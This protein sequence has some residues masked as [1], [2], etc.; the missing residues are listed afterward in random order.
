MTSKKIT[1]PVYIEGL[2]K[3]TPES[4]VEFGQ[5][6]SRLFA[7]KHEEL[8]QRMK[9]WRIEKQWK[10]DGVFTLIREGKSASQIERQQKVSRNTV[11][12]YKNKLLLQEPNLICPCGLPLSHKG[13]CSIR[14]EGRVYIITSRKS[15][16][17]L[18]YLRW[19]FLTS[20]I[21]VPSYLHTIQEYVPMTL[22]EQIRAE[23]CQDLSLAIISGEI[24]E[25]QIPFVAKD[26]VRNVFKLYPTKYGPLSLDQIIPGTDGLTL[27]DTIVG[28]DGRKELGDETY[29][30]LEKE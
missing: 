28:Q 5:L 14:K 20:G 16:P 1:N 26:F 13:L 9:E 12:V 6:V 8:E 21:N 30:A 7:V 24:V 29:S 25:E 23:V 10:Y 4:W 15:E 19:P 27:M 22:P 11:N 3:G 17:S 18:P 2:A